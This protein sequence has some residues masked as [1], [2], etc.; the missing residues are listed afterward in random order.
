MQNKINLKRVLLGGLIAGIVLDLVG[1]LIHGVILNSHY[2]YFQKVGSMLTQAR[3]MPLQIIFTVLCGFPMA[4]L[5]AIART[6]L[7]PGPKCAII[8]GLLIGLCTMGESMA[9]Y[10]YYNLGAMIPALTFLNN[11]GGA[12]LGTF[13][14]G[15]IYKDKAV[16]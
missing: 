12:V 1:F 7:G 13:V 8:V 16:A 2:V 4:F 9:V 15:M 3:F 14:A 11:I 5:Y 10:S 6:H